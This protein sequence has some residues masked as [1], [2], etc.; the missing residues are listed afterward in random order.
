MR[1]AFWRNTLNEVENNAKSASGNEVMSPA[2]LNRF[3][4]DK[5]AQ[6]VADELW[7][8]RPQELADIR[9]VFEALASAEGSS[10]TR[11]AGSSGTPA[12]MSAKFDAALSPASIASRF[13]SVTRHQMSP[14]IAGVDL[15]STYLR[16]KKAG[17]MASAI[18]RI[19]T[20]VVNNPELA[21]VL[22]E[23]YNPA[24]RVAKRRMLTQKFGA[25][26]TYI[27]NLLDESQRDD[28][29]P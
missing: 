7:S 16:R 6:A 19:T 20:D 2:K 4:K 27:A 22:L 5:K 23:K 3:L 18:D 8:D 24:D 11:L 9:K 26:G 21:A 12:G 25:R 29:G 17:V 14:T 13:R 15:I 28:E 10:R 1:D